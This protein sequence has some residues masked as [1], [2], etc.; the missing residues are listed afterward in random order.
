[1]IRIIA[2]TDKGLQLAHRLQTL[3]V[4]SSVWFKPKPFT[5]KIQYA[6]QQGDTLLMICATGIVVRT[7]APVLQN[8]KA[9]PPVLV[10]DEAGQFVIPLLSGHEGGANQLA[11]HIATQLAATCV[12]TTA[13]SYTQAI[14]TVGMGCER[15]CPLFALEDLFLHCLQQAKLTPYELK[16][17]NSI[18]LK[19]DEV[20][21]IALAEKYH[22]PFLTWSVDELSTVEHQLSTKSAYVYEITGIYGVAE[23]AA[24]YAAQQTADAIAFLSLAKQKN[25]QA[26]CAIACAY[27]S[28]SGKVK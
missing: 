9:D 5:Q 12:L 10:L 3:L 25:K 23:S 16:S 14:Y 8:K 11:Q 19:N 15:G 26:T 21:L 7:L 20:G 13:K 28:Y 24:L 18:A 4:N 2:L 1:M 22:R 27:P 17:I 6:F